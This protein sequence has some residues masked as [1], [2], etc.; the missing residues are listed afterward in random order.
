MNN[1]NTN[2]SED[3]QHQSIH[4]NDSVLHSYE[5][6][7]ALIQHEIQE[8]QPMPSFTFTVQEEEKVAE[9]VAAEGVDSG[10]SS[11]RSGVSMSHSI[12][13]TLSPPKDS[14]THS[15]IPTPVQPLFLQP[16]SA[17]FPQ[18]QSSAQ[19][20]QMLSDKWSEKQRRTSIA[21]IPL[22][23]A[24][25]LRSSVVSGIGHPE[26]IDL[27][28][29]GRVI[30]RHIKFMLAI[31]LS[32]AM[33]LIRPA[34]IALG[35]SPYLA[36]ITV[37]FMHPSRT[38]GSQLEV[39]VFAVIG[40]IVAM[41]WNM[42]G[43]LCV[44]SFNRHHLP[45][46]NHNSWVIEALWFFVGIW[47]MTTLKA[48]YAKL[49][50]T[51]QI[52][53]MTSIFALNKMRN[54][55]EVRPRDCIN[56]LGPMLL[57]VAIS[58]V[59]N[60]CF[61]PETASDG[62]GRAL[63]E[64]LD[65]SRALLNLST[66]SF[67][68][69]HQAIALPK[70]AM[71]KAQAGVKNAQKKLLSAYR[72]ARYEVTYSVT[73]PTDYKE[74]RI[75]VSALMRHLGAMSLVVQNERLL[76][77][78]HPDRDNDDLHTDSE[79]SSISSPGH[80]TN[81]TGRT[82][83]RRSFGGD[84][85]DESDSYSDREDSGAGVGSSSHLDFSAESRDSTDQR[86]QKQTPHQQQQ[87]Q[88]QRFHQRRG[89]AAELRRVRQLLMRA[90]VSTERILQARKEQKDRQKAHLKEVMLDRGLRTEPSSPFE[91]SSNTSQPGNGEQGSRRIRSNSITAMFDNKLRISATA[92]PSLRSSS[93]SISS[94]YSSSSSSTKAEPS[95]DIR[96]QITVKSFRSL[97]S[98]S[99]KTDFVFKRPGSTKG[100]FGRRG[101]R[102]NASATSIQC[103]AA[104]SEIGSTIGSTLPQELYSGQ[105]TA[106]SMQEH[107]VDKIAAAFRKKKEREQK[108]ARKKA[109]Q[110]M[111]TEQIRISKEEQ[112]MADARARPPK[113]VAFGDRKLFMSF[114][115]I[116]Q[117]PLQRLSDSCSRSMVSLERELVA[118]LNVEKDRQE[119]IRKR[120]AQRDDI[121]RK[122]DAQRA[123]EENITSKSGEIS[124]SLGN[125]SS[126]RIGANDP[127]NVD[128]KSK[129]LWRWILSLGKSR[130]LTQDELDYAKSLKSA[131]ESKKKVKNANP[132]LEKDTAC[133]P[134]ESEDDGGLPIGVSYVEFITHELEVFDRAEAAGLQ[135]FI[136]SHPSLDVSPR[137]EIFLIF[138]FIFALREIARELLRLG[139]YVEELD[140]RQLREMEA[141]GRHK[142]KRHLWWPKV[143]NFWHWFGWVG[144]SQT[145]VSGGYGVMIMNTTNLMEKQGPCLVAEEKLR[146]EAEAASAF[147]AEQEQK[148]KETR[149][150]KRRDNIHETYRRQR[151]VTSMGVVLENNHPFDI[152]SGLRRSGGQYRTQ[153]YTPHLANYNTQGLT[154][155]PLTSQKLWPSKYSHPVPTI[156]IHPLSPELDVGVVSVEHEMS[157]YNKSR[158]RS[159]DQLQ[160]PGDDILSYH[161]ERSARKQ[162][163]KILPLQY[164]V[165]NISD[166]N[167]SE[168][169]STEQERIR[170][171]QGQ[172]IT[173]SDTILADAYERSRTT[174]SDSF[175]HVSTTPI[176]SDSSAT[177]PKARKSNS[178]IRLIP[179]P[180][181]DDTY[182][183]DRSESDHSSKSSIL[184]RSRSSSA[185]GS[186]T[187]SSYTAISFTNQN[188][189][190]QQ[191]LR[192]EQQFQ[193]D[194][195]PSLSSNIPPAIK[196]VLINVPK[197][198]TWRMR[199][200]KW[201]QT[202]KTDEVR[203]GFKMSASMSFI[204][205][206]AWLDWDDQIFA[207][208]RGQWAMMT[209]MAVLWPTV[210]AM[211]KVIILRTGG[212][213]I[214][215]IWALLT[216]LACPNNPYVICVF[217]LPITFVAA[218]F[219][220]ISAHPRL[221]IILMLAYS[222]ITFTDYHGQTDDT[223][224][225][226]S[227]K[228]AIAVTLG[229][230]I[231]VVMNTFLWPVLARH[232]LR[233]EIAL[234]VGR[235][236]VLF[237]ELVN[238]FLLEESDPNQQ[239]TS[240][241]QSRKKSR[242]KHRRMSNLEE[243]T[244]SRKSR[245]GGVLNDKGEKDEYPD[246]RASATLSPSP[247]YFET[248]WNK[249][250]QQ[251]TK[252]KVDP[253]RAAFQRIEQQLQTRLINIGQLLE[254]SKSEPRLKEDFPVQLYTQIVKCCQ[255]IL[256]RMVSMRMSAQLLSPEVRELVTGPMNFYRRDMVGALLMYFNVLSS[257]LASKS[258][259]PPY[260]PSA[261]MARLRV[262]FNVRKAIAAHQA[263]TGEDH[264]TYIYYYAFSSALEEV[265]EE[266][267]LLAILIKPLV[268]ITM[269]SSVNS[270]GYG[271]PVDQTS[272]FASV[273][274]EPP[275]TIP[276]A[277]DRRYYSERNSEL[278][279]SERRDW[280]NSCGAPVDLELGVRLAPCVNEY[281]DPGSPQIQ[282]QQQLLRQQINFQQRQNNTLAS[283]YAS[284]DLS[285]GG[286]FISTGASI[287][288]PVLSVESSAGR[289]I[290]EF[291]QATGSASM[292][293]SCPPP[294]P[295]NQMG[296]PQ[297]SPS[298]SSATLMDRDI[299]LFRNRHAYRYENAIRLAQ[300][301]SDHE[302]L[303]VSSPMSRKDMIFKLPPNSPTRFMSSTF[304]TS[305]SGPAVNM[306]GTSNSPRAITEVA[307]AAYTGMFSPVT[308]GIVGSSS[309]LKRQLERQL[310]I[311]SSIMECLSPGGRR[312][313]QTF[314]PTL[315]RQ[316]SSVGLRG[317]PLKQL[318]H[319]RQEKLDVLALSSPIQN[320]GEP[321]TTSSPD[322]SDS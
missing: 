312:R 237:A 142:R 15:N 308:G 95:D 289:N 305:A 292:T 44:T 105:S 172:S 62:L 136:S 250:Q 33:T 12:A 300:E 217:M 106:T 92:A 133:K 72:E 150:Q 252:T 45:Q 156:S 230:L 119:R 232:E 190:E 314:P 293:A 65:S 46:G 248:Q 47:I 196:T 66:R 301:A 291:G 23:I 322:R 109:M 283:S 228:R 187:D 101:L 16:L 132:G 202:F 320:S 282:V 161:S 38:V 146:I 31:Y 260:L 276:M 287:N 21:T 28:Q 309:M 186:T 194:Q 193:Q 235:Q 299:S 214:G 240:T 13:N 284:L 256:D 100:S 216:Y 3:E 296:A 220:L 58:L 174:S 59:V 111:K 263:E 225:E 104:A 176:S 18:S 112:Q 201:F 215:V 218:Y 270:Y 6:D 131:R 90:E 206:W 257:S 127:P 25:S 164:T 88:Q 184:R 249:R 197:P 157:S 279:E 274:P 124:E 285:Q 57:G 317:T 168:T 74:A 148:E 212:T 96:N 114:L 97:F 35:P 68:L 221:G 290:D 313:D 239:I 140:A 113:E 171:M 40:A 294:N 219:M 137:E 115:D 110:E 153:G 20:N 151:S 98:V 192:K 61:W 195:E 207:L 63:S 169:D 32:S 79:D 269:I 69:N 165:V 211:V 188:H 265:I 251:Y 163:N 234:L 310:M 82:N 223:I 34:A 71:E 141:E 229:I 247:Q 185:P 26:S 120:N 210:G 267:E 224:Y 81:D 9:K 182:E 254:L 87:Q 231:C 203:Y 126:Q 107:Q 226:L 94:S 316:E 99:S 51:F 122:A 319:E 295:T 241:Q 123:T 117:E 242:R 288:S 189:P 27:Q 180:S 213:I 103:S 102:G 116:V 304:A 303:E 170:S 83:S 145:R 275:M 227:Y 78:G 302:L 42:L 41:I 11:L 236:G 261:R 135:K 147:R 84:I 264:Y 125:D 177:T 19:P 49:V 222:S 80:S 8:V 181:E 64:S 199:T 77:L 149:D 183:G 311:D 75:V 128:K 155:N 179:S 17:L 130:S 280:L 306:V 36:N 22:S 162:D 121:I 272:Y 129:Y 233:K 55:M 173:T 134:E 281:E 118:G 273:S 268:G 208:D 297:L 209:V 54:S 167:G 152:E 24:R 52:F 244:D 246:L 175:A 48:R 298:L 286:L 60:I 73:N 5:T 53:T 10:S 14:Y 307:P 37:I 143:A 93:S 178:T 245:V 70:S 258:P 321:S 200:W 43:Q 76:M 29:P 205:L 139:K 89:S 159:S 166:H 30:T 315:N 56:L 1:R 238:K 243:Y 86:Q 259:L 204:A 2:P 277:R 266:L 158:Y 50:G 91:V 198:K 67:L 154:H 108:R 255:N 39:T 160:V 144:Y 318:L 278:D 262:M 7:A 191:W 271:C 138:F 85:D 4:G 253:E